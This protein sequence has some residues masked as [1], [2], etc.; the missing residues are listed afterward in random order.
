MIGVGPGLKLAAEGERGDGLENGEGKAPLAGKGEA[1]D[2]Y[3][4]GVRERRAMALTVAVLGG[5]EH[6]GFSKEHVSMVDL[7]A[8]PRSTTHHAARREQVGFR[9][10]LMKK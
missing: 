10:R 7:A 5:R 6:F 2:A 1:I 3:L 9:A 8:D 4:V